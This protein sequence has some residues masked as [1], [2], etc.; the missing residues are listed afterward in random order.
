MG[1]ISDFVKGV[2]LPQQKARQALALDAEFENALAHAQK[3]DA[4]I[5]QLEAEVNPLKREVEALKQKIT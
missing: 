5:L 3:S 4:R 2:A 1:K